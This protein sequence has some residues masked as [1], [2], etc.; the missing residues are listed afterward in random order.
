MWKLQLKKKFSRTV[1]G[2]WQNESRI[3]KKKTLSRLISHFRLSSSTHHFHIITVKK[4]MKLKKFLMSETCSCHLIFKQ[5]EITITLIEHNLNE[6]STSLKYLITSISIKFPVLYQGV[7]GS[8][9]KEV[10]CR[11]SDKWD[12]F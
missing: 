11:Y 2:I 5:F 8:E 6:P 12:T 10:T 7:I 9:D 3:I 4:S 1:L